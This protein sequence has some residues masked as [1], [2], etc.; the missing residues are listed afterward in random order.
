MRN[1]APFWQKVKQGSPE[2]CWPW[3]GYVGPSGH[4]MTSLDSLPLYASRKA[5]LLTHGPIRGNLCVNHKS[6]KVCL[7]QAICCNPN[8][9]YLGTRSDNMVDRWTKTSADER[10]SYGRPYVLTPE[11]MLQLWEMRRNGATLEACAKEFGVH[12]ATIG[13]YVT[14]KRRLRIT[15][16][17]ADRLSAVA[18][19]T[20]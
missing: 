4:G 9:M 19:V 1:R 8:H 17:R 11:Q 18:K 14:A 15:Q 13:R 3:T 2:E 5:W 12:R 20:I 6:T 10:S 7:L 16:L